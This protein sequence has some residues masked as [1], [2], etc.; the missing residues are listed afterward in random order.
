[1]IEP[2]KILPDLTTERLLLRMLKATDAID[3]Y[4]YASD[5]E[6]TTHLLWE[7]HQSMEDT[8][9]FVAKV[10]MTYDNEEPGIW[11]IVDRSI[12]KVIGTIGIHNWR[13]MHDAVEIGYVIG[14]PNWNKGY[15]TEVVEAVITYLF[16]ELHINRVDAV[17][18]VE[19][20]ASEQ[21]MKKVGMQFEGIQRKSCF[22]KGEF[23]DMKM[24]AILRQDRFTQKELHK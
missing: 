11:G 20:S 17:C 5:P 15:M 18:A 16:K 13:R 6:V 2:P 24:Y 14:R 4:Q 19:N 21:V 8:L 9:E 12:G 7:T 10:L 23:H 1:M 22:I 3:I